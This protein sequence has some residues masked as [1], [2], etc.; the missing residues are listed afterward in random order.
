MNI[1]KSKSLLSHLNRR[2]GRLSMVSKLFVSLNKSYALF[3]ILPK[4]NNREEM[5]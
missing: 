3:A 2:G 1:G 5:L 4:K